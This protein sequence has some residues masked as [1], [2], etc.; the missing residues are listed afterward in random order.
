MTEAL[1]P[2]T[3]FF[4]EFSSLGEEEGKK[5]I[6]AVKDEEQ[7]FAHMARTEGWDLL[8]EMI[9]EQ[10]QS[11]DQMVRIAMEQ[12]AGFEEIGR[13]TAV[14]E[15]T[16]DVLKRIVERVEEAREASDRRSTQ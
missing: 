13:K 2:S 1:R 6:S 3:N 5:D 9:D 8:K 4:T 14:K 10:I 11:M 12:G 15:V 16:K 7:K